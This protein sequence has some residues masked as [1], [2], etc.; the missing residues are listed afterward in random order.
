[1]LKIYKNIE[2][3]MFGSNNSLGSISE[4]NDNFFFS[5]IFKANQVIVL[6]MIGLSNSNTTRYQVGSQSRTN[7]CI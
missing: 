3:K 4:Q 5:K 6:A 2:K 7:A 1:M